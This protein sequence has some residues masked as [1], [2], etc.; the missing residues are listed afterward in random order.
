MYEPFIGSIFYLPYNFQVHGFA[1]CR[2]QLIPIQQNTALFALL[3]TTFGGDGVH[4]FALPD[5]RKFK[6]PGV[7]YQLGEKLPD[8]TPY[9]YAQ[10][11]LVGIFPSRD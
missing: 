4:N 11:A 8:G 5:L 7:E 1:F 9:L 3:G 2:G 6:S 10:I